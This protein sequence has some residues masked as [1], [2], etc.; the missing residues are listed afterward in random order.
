MR[1]IQLILL[2]LVQGAAFVCMKI[3][4]QTIPPFD[5]VYIR[6]LTAAVILLVLFMHEI[7]SGLKQIIDKI[8]VIFILSITS[9]IAPFTL[10]AWAETKMPSGIPSIYMALIPIVVALIGAKYGVEQKLGK[11]GYI[12]LLISVTGIVTLS[13]QSILGNGVSGLWPNI[14]CLISTLFYSISIL[15]VRRLHM[16][17]SYVISTSV[18]VIASA[19]LTPFFLIHTNYIY[20]FSLASII[21]SLVLGGLSTALALILMYNLVIR[22]GG[23]FATQANYIVPIAG[24]LWGLIVLGEKIPLLIIPSVAMVLYGLWLVR[25]RMG[26]PEKSRENFLDS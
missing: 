16:I 3:G 9:I 22:H 10:L 18:L 17:G 1:Y 20:N 23:V 2:G 21:A 24:L 26:L 11:M 12:G 8:G 6:V 4:V 25:G 5:V 19:L 14:A 15:I 7:K 13:V